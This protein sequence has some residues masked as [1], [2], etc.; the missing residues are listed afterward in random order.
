MVLLAPQ[1]LLDST[2]QES[3]HMQCFDAALKHSW[4]EHTDTFSRAA[5]RLPDSYVYLIAIHDGGYSESSGV[6]E[7]GL[8]QNKASHAF[9]L[10][11]LLCD[12]AH[13][14]VCLCVC[15]CACVLL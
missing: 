9:S 4:C 3:E 10:R 14:F 12:W 8:Q 5:W 7:P 1:K 13:L 15:A 6:A 11:P 2:T